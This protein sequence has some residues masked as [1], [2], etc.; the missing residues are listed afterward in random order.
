MNA[1]LDQETLILPQA[2]ATAAKKAMSLINSIDLTMMKKKLMDKEEGQG[3]DEEF[4]AYAEIRYKRYLC[5][6]F[7][8]PEKSIAPARRDVST[9]HPAAQINGISNP[10]PHFLKRI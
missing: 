5:L 3:W 8:Y 6:Q 4:T 9:A 10:L 7:L 1:L 2:N